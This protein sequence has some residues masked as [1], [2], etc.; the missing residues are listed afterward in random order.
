M[1]IPG[2]SIIIPN[3]HSPRIGEVL[4]ALYRQSGIDGSEVEI[5]V[6]GQDK[7]GLVKRHAAKDKRIMFL[8]TERVLNPAEARNKGIKEARGKLVFLIDADCIAS[9]NWMAV[10]LRRYGEG[11]PVVGGPM[12]FESGQYWI[13]SDNVA[14]FHDLLP[15]IGRGV[16]RHFMLASAN[17][18]VEKAVLEKVG[19]FDE[20]FPT[21]ED[22]G[23]S[24]KL[25]HAGYDLFF[26][27]D[28]KIIHRP[29]RDNISAVLRHS[30]EWG[31]NSIRIRSKYKDDLNTPFF[32][33]RPLLLRLLSPLIASAVTLKIFLRHPSVRR[34]WYTFPVVFLTK[35]V[36]CWTVAGE[37]AAGRHLVSKQ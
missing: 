16:N 21:G 30:K 29:V 11:N 12:W 7:Y 14:H 6:V 8:E 18:M 36:W 32:L 35:M 25:R 27:P 9:K 37:V 17:L 20:D 15:D 31:K 2:Y 34:Y 4:E 5:I 13:L 23:L 1:V 24:L 3:L 33:F 10:L 26:E 19:M 28:A 22:F